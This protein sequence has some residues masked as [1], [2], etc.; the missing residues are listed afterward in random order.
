MMSNVQLFTGY[1]RIPWREYFTERHKEYIGKDLG[2][3]VT[4]INKPS[5]IEEKCAT[6]SICNSYNA[7]LLK[8]LNK[9]FHFIGKDYYANKKIY[10]LI[11]RKTRPNIVLFEYG[12]NCSLFGYECYALG[13]PFV[14]HFH[15]HDVTKAYNDEKYRKSIIDICKKSKTVIANS[16]CTQSRLIEIGIP[17][18]LI[19]L[20]YMGVFIPEKPDKLPDCKKLKI[21]HIANYFKIKGPLETLK[22]FEFSQRLGLDAELIMIGT[23]PLLSECRNFVAEKKL[24]NVYFLGSLENNEVLCKLKDCHILTQHS[25]RTMDNSIEGFG[26]SLVE[27]MAMNRAVVASDHGPFR[28][29]IIDN[30]TGLLFPEGDWNAQG[31]ALM[32]LANDRNCLKQLSL[33]GY[34][35]AKEMF[36]THR[37]SNVLRNILGLRK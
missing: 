7:Y 2:S 29:I 22:A 31:R 21:I 16:K 1:W 19:K 32:R 30:V 23:G 15:G 6:Y 14:V 25:I 33:K 12:T 34:H 28:E 26:L 36:S 9:L 13:I 20:K 4:V 10:N 18:S 8:I 5:A 24:C 37:E 35:R 3:L 11:L 17:E 27:A